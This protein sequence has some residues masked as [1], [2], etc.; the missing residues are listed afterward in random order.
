[1]ADIQY[2]DSLKVQGTPTLYFD[3]KMIDGRILQSPVTIRQ[4]LDTAVGPIN[5]ETVDTLA[6]PVLNSDEFTS[7][8]EM[9]ADMPVVSDETASS[10]SAE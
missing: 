8:V 4:F 7:G 5:Q 3:G 9:P 10:D 1:M 6:V 2:G